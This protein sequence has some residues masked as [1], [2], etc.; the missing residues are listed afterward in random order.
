M[1]V[2]VDTVAP[3][4]PVIASDAIVNANEVMLTGTAEA[5]SKVNVFDGWDATWYGD[6][7][8]QRGLELYD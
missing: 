3:A 8:W 6:N 4:A 1:S 7:G 2:T 5:N